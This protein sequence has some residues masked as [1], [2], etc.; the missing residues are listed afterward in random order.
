M[1]VWFT[2]ITFENKRI[3]FFW[4][5]LYIEKVGLIGNIFARVLM[6]RLI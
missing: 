1:T 4:T 2:E 3:Y 6:E 5:F